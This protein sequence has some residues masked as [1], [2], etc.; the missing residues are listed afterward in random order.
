MKRRWPFFVLCLVMILP[1]LFSC[2]ANLSVLEEETLMTEAMSLETLPDKTNEEENETVNQKP[3]NNTP[4]PAQDKEINVLFIGS[5]SCYYYIDELYGLYEAAGYKNVTLCNVY[6]SGCM[7][8]QHWEWLRGGEAKYEFFI[9]DS[10]GRRSAKNVD[11]K[12]C[13]K[14]KNWDHISLLQSTGVIYS[15]GEEA[16]RKTIFP[17]LKNL[18]EYLRQRF[19]EAQYYWQQGWTQELGKDLHTTEAQIAATG[20]YRRVAETAAADYNMTWAPLGEAWDLVRGNPIIYEGGKNL[21][22]R[23]FLGKPDHDDL[24]H[25]GD[26]GGGQYLNACVWFEMLTGDSC[27]DNTFMPQYSFE[28]KDLSLSEEKI[29][30]LKNAAHAAVAGVYGEDFAK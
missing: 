16:Y 17:Y 20:I 8:K 5:S 9:T 4:D 12:Y 28:G 30:L 22:T 29:T 26:V 6:Y 24:S 21:T 19:P 18:M 7:L 13:L 10:S 27:L 15:Q 2:S 3:Q 1:N 25:D 14:Y 11:L 23:I